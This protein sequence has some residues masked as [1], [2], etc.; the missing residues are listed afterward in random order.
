MYSALLSSITQRCD[1]N[2]VLKKNDIANAEDSKRK[3]ASRKISLTCQTL[4]TQRRSPPTSSLR[5]SSG[6][7]RS[8]DLSPVP[9]PSASPKPTVI[10]SRFQITLVNETKQIVGPVSKASRFTV[11]NVKE[12]TVKTTVGFDIPTEP[13]ASAEPVTPN[14]G[15][16]KVE[17][18][19]EG[20]KGFESQKSAVMDKEKVDD[21][22]FT[23]QS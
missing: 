14:N 11:Y 13:V 16:H 2:Q 5:T 7:L 12:S 22:L 18:A 23:G 17:S 20:F 4:T 21:Q 15:F 8:P 3:K 6:R 19:N 9:S 1:A 10:K